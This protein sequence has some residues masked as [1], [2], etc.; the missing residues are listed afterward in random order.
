[1]KSKHE[2]VEIAQ[3]GASIGFNISEFDK[4]DIK[5][6]AEALQDGCTLELR[7]SDA[8]GKYDVAEI[9]RSAPSKVKFIF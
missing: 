4:Y 5:S 7:G 9:A 3:A 1:M 6:I 2:L 8:M